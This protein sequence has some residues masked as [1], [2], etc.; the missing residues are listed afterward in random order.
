MALFDLK[1]D[2]LQPAVLGRPATDA[3]RSAVLSAVRRQIAEVLHRPLL[4]VCWDQVV[5]GDAL[6]ALDA[7]GQVVT[8]EV[9]DVLDSTAL[10]LAM[11]RA[12][13]AACTGRAQLAARYP[14]GPSAFEK[15]WDRFRGS[16]PARAEPG[17][18][19][20]LLTTE[21]AADVRTSFGMIAE[22]GVELHELRVRSTEDGRALVSVEQLRTDAASQ[23]PVLNWQAAAPA[24]E[25]EDDPQPDDATA[26]TPVIEPSSPQAD[27]P[28]TSAPAGPNSGHRLDAAVLGAEPTV[29]S[30]EASERALAG[31]A[32]TI[33]TPATLVWLRRRRGIDHRATLAADGTITLADGATFRDPSAAANAAQR[34]QDID[35]WRVW[36]VG[37]GGPSLRDLLA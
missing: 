15:D 28:A 3:D 37:V 11:A 5:G 12:T 13:N 20:T 32:Q 14:G 19:L 27:V 22:S 26:P 36:R 33:E 23:A 29:P 34:T 16:M 24:V 8:I 10:L 35:G 6:T 25:T 2:R 1:D 31:I 4:P 30:G 7:A 21:I 18:R 9:I 17:P